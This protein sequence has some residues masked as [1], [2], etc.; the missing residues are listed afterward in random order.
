MIGSKWPAIPPSRHRNG[1]PLRSSALDIV[2]PPPPLDPQVGHRLTYN[3][4]S[5]SYAVTV[6]E[7]KP[8]KVITRNDRSRNAGD[9]YGE[10]RWLSVPN[11][12]GTVHEFT[13]RADGR[14]HSKGGRR[15]TGFLSGGSHQSLDPNF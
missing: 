3:I 11:P 7:R 5:D 1:G 13:L 9:W 8:R 12:R 2:G 10:Q 6:V 14:W 4:G 15:N